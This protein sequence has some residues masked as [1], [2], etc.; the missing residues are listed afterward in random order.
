MTR[1]LSNL[2]KA[3]VNQYKKDYYTRVIDYNDLLEQKLTAMS[4]EQETKRRKD[5]LEQLRQQAKTDASS[6][7]AQE[8]EELE[9]LERQAAAPEFREG[10]YAVSPE[11]GIDYVEQ[12][13]EEANQIT[14]KATADA[15][16]ILRRAVAE[17]EG[18]KEKARKEAENRGY[19]EG[20]A[21]AQENESRMRKELEDLRRQQEQAYE[22]RLAQMEP[23]LMDVVVEVFDQVL[24]S[25]LAQRKQILLHLI[26]QTVQQVKSSREFRIRVSAEDYPDIF[27]KR[28]EI[29]QKIGGEVTLDVIMDESM[30][31][32]KCTIDTEEGIF[33]CGLDVQLA[34]LVRD[35]KALSCMG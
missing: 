9:K 4:F 2:Y 29:L 3:Q 20:M 19:S 16:E 18:I 33:D 23:E 1:S 8:L 35:L 32:G 11:L 22:Q 34:N 28:E 25:D 14:A 21:R 26:R 10:L 12:A 7:D 6:I 17:A 5:R 24:Q 13:K 15:E 31:Q 30:Q 27:A